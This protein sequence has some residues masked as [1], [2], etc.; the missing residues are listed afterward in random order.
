MRRFNLV[1]TILDTRSVCR[2]FQLQEQIIGYL[3]AELIS[4]GSECSAGDGG[5]EIS[6]GKAMINRDQK[7]DSCI[8]FGCM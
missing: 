1:C 5:G 8:S 6:C 3:V 2:S 7:R 4:T